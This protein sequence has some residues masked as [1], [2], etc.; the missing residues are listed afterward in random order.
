[1]LVQTPIPPP[2]LPAPG[3]DPTF[4]LN[5]ALETGVMVLIVIVIGI[6]ALKVL[7]PL[8][9]AWAHRLEGRSGDPQLRADM[10][11]MREQLAEVDSLRARMGELEDRLEF[12][13]RLLSQRRDQD[14][15]QRGGPRE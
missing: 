9:R 15:L 5:R 13:E 2:S 6:V 8:T 10:E 11:Q 12:A 4:A 3:I 1:M 7:G 14:L